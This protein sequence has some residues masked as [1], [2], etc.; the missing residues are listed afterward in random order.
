LIVSIG[1]WVAEELFRQARE[2]R[3]QGIDLE[4]I[5]FNV[6]PRQ[7]WQPKLVETIVG[8]LEASGIDADRVVIEIT[9]SA[10]MTDPERTQRTLWDLHARGFRLAIDDFGTGYSS[11]SRLKAMP[12]SILK[13]DRAF[14]KDIPEDP[15]AVRMVSAIVGLAKSLD[16][17]PL[18]E[19]IETEEQK[20]FLVESGCELGQGYYFSRPVPAAG[21]EEIHG[22]GGVTTMTNDTAP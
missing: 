17:R 11:L 14:V 8:H 6:S 7:L 13:I 18:A 16:M 20:R 4:E 15:D 10:A 22:R 1:D 9:E 12:V 2:W 5:S 19:G 21:I 3:D